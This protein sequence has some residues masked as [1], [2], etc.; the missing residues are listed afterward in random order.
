[1]HARTILAL[2]VLSASAALAGCGD[3]A[4]PTDAGSPPPD[5]GP[6]PP[7]AGADGGPGDGDAGAD[8]G[9]CRL[10]HLVVVA[11]DFVTAELGALDLETGETTAAGAP[12]A[13]QDTVA[14]TVGCRGALLHR[15]QGTLALLSAGDPLETERTVDLNPAGAVGP[16]AVNP[17][18]V[19]AAEGDRA[20]VVP[21]ATNE[22]IAVDTAA[23]AVVARTDLSSHVAATDTDMLVD[24]TDAI[25]VGETLWVAL[26]RFWFDESFAIHF[27]GSLLVGVDAATGELGEAIPLLGDNP[28]R[29]MIHDR[30]SGELWIGSAG[31]S[32]ALDGGVERVDLATGASN[33][34]LIEETT[35]GAELEGIAPGT[36]S[37]LNV[38]AGGSIRHV[39]PTSGE[40][41]GEPYATDVTGLVLHA[42]AVWAW[43]PSGL[44]AFDAGAGADISSAMGGPWTF[45]SLPIVSAAPAP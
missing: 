29:G 34:W 38:L 44:R 32:F 25:L 11:S 22:V 39:D 17:Q 7:D 8:A 24:G 40:L 33:G 14:A 21:Q 36:S 19:V 30:E 12:L 6:P 13:D 31:D 42:G 43:G 28:W 23:G 20:W 15:G 2:A 3:D 9:S 16:Y 1:M 5:A 18:R 27:E 37:R 45:G 41:V 35:L 4:T 26:G 10:D